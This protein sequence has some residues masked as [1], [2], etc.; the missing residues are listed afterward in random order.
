MESYS[1]SRLPEWNYSTSEEA[2]LSLSVPT[3]AERGYALKITTNVPPII[4][5]SSLHWGSSY[6]RVGLSSRRWQKFPAHSSSMTVDNEP[7]DPCNVLS[8][9]MARINRSRSESVPAW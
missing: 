3:H 1:T 6:I 9:L 4:E 8:S 7:E 2:I 5:K